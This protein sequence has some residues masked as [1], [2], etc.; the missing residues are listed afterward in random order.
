MPTVKIVEHFCHTP[1]FE[2]QASD[3][4]SIGLGNGSRMLMVSGV[5]AERPDGEWMQADMI[6]A[7]DIHGQLRFV[8][9]RIA[10]LLA[11]H[12]GTVGDIV[13]IVIYTTDARYLMD[14]IGATLST[15]F[16][17]GE[18]PA[19]TGMVVSGL[20]WPEMLVEI[21]VTAVVDGE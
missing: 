1:K 10:E 12:G 18:V 3:V 11:L 20:A 14:P 6:S 19:A 9:D 13:K 7:Q 5:A 8:W 17:G 16:A 4:V 2:G 21:D 15:I